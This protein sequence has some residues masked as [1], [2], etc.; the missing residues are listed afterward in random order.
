MKQQT[1]VPF[2]VLAALTLAVAGASYSALY[3][4][5]L[6]PV[7]GEVAAGQFAASLT[8]LSG[9]L[10]ALSVELSPGDGECGAIGG[11]WKHADLAT[12]VSS[13]QSIGCR[14]NPEGFTNDNVDVLSCPTSTRTLSLILRDPMSSGPA[15]G[16]IGLG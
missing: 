6:Q 8:E 2:A 14:L 1:Q 16:F 3:Y 12:L 4:N 10:P 11:Y 9:K 15:E 7:C 13:A 5:V